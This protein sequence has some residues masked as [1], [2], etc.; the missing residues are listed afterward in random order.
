MQSTQAQEVNITADIEDD[1]DGAGAADLLS[2]R[3]PEMVATAGDSLDLADLTDVDQYNAITTG[4]TEYKRTL[5]FVE[6]PGPLDIRCWT[7]CLTHKKRSDL[8]HFEGI[9]R[10]AQYRIFNCRKELRKAKDG[11]ALLIRITK[12]VS[13][14]AIYEHWA[15]M[16][17]EEN[18]RIGRPYRPA[19][20]PLMGAKDK[21]EDRMPKSSKQPKPINRIPD[22]NPSSFNG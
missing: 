7:N 8:T 21:D 4:R 9:L 14:F 17:L 19:R 22:W 16:V 10:E 20:L 12:L 6:N 13:A 3:Y 1:E 2:S 15:A 5:R 18:I 11:A